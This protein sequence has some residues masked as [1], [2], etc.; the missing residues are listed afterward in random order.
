M[1]NA[2]KKSIR[3]R[4]QKRGNIIKRK[5]ISN[6]YLGYVF[7]FTF[8][9]VGIGTSKSIKLTQLVYR[10]THKLFIAPFSILA[11]F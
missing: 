7:F 6:L 2:L 9:N 3:R 10:H 5:G 11:H 4:S 1:F 8:Q